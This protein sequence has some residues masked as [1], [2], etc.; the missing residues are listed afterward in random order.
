MRMLTIIGGVLMLLTG[1]FCFI[2]PGQTFLAIAFVI[3]L[4]MVLNGLIHICAYMMGRGLN[5][6]GDNNGWILTDALITLLLGILVLCNQL[7]ADTAIPL[8]FGMWVLVSGILRIEAATHINLERKRENFRI[9]MITGVMTVVVGLFGFINPLVMFLS[10]VVLMGFF[11][12]M[13]GINIIEL[14]IDMP[15]QRKAYV[16]IYKRKREPVRITPEEETEE[17]VQELVSTMRGDEKGNLSDVTAEFY[18][19]LAIGGAFRKTAETLEET[20]KRAD[21]EMYKNKH[22]VRKA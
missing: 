11:M 7:V 19:R 16:K 10:T 1:I 6:K 15:H 9:T 3:G 8:V 4:V 22:F 21:D 5:N 12:V 13:Q 2:N 18:C 14:G 17:K 20:I